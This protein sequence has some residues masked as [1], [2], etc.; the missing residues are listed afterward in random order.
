MDQ[1]TPFDLVKML[2]GHTIKCAAE[3]VYGTVPVYLE[4]HPHPLAPDQR[5][6]DMVAALP[7]SERWALYAKIWELAKMEDSRVA[8][9]KWGEQH[10]FDDLPRLNAAMHRLGL[11]VAP[12]LYRVECIPFRF[13]EGGLGAQYFSLGERLGRDP[14]S[15]RIG[16]VNSVFQTLFSDSHSPIAI[17]TAWASGR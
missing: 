15:G 1:N 16:F 5:Y 2:V 8:G 10:A 12:G 7:D 3:R 6:R 17:S 4:L 14:L 9:W 13:G 11:F